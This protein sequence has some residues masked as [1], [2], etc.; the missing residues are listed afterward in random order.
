M[1]QA[2][3]KQWE[4]GQANDRGGGSGAKYFALNYRATSAMRR[5]RD[6]A[7]T[8]DGKGG[9]AMG[10]PHFALNYRAASRTRC[11]KACEW[12]YEQCSAVLTMQWNS[13]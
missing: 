7:S 11:G 9:G 10:V 1:S 3:R 6:Y 8:Y 5:T 2:R 12:G 13:E 4:V